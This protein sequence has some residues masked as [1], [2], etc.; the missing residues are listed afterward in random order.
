MIDDTSGK[1]IFKCKHC[2]N[3]DLRYMKLSNV[4]INSPQYANQMYRDAW[5]N[6]GAIQSIGVHIECA[7]CNKDTFIIPDLF[8]S[9]EWGNDI[10]EQC[11]T[12]VKFEKPKYLAIK[13]V[14][15]EDGYLDRVVETS[16]GQF[17]SM[18]TE[19]VITDPSKI[20]A[21]GKK[22]Y[23]LLL[24]RGLREIGRPTI[25]DVDKKEDASS[26]PKASIEDDRRW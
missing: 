17:I 13:Y 11:V 24:S 14:M 19:E 3:D 6:R 9:I 7:K 1:I 4:F 15:T 8:S 10:P 5:G 18:I 25:I 26:S 16:N 20:S 2:D 21:I 12:Q 23:D 22:Q